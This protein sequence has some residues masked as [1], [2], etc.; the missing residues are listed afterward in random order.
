VVIPR[1]FEF[2]H[3]RMTMSVITESDEQ[4]RMV[5]CKGAAEKIAELCIPESLPDGFIEEAEQW[6]K[7]GA[8]VLG[9]CCKG[10]DGAVDIH[11]Y[12]RDDVEEKQSFKCL[13]L[14]LFR[15][16]LKEDTKEAMT[17][18][19]EG[20]CRTI[21]ITGDNA[22]CGYYIAKE[23]GMIAK[24]AK[25]Y[26]ADVSRQDASMVVWKRQDAGKR[27]PEESVGKTDELDS[28]PSEAIT[29]T[30]TELAMTGK[31]FDILEKNGELDNLILKTRI[32]ARAS[33]N[34]KTL[35]IRKLIEKGIVCGYCGD[36]GNDCGALRAAHAGLALSEAEAS[37]VAPFTGK[38]KSVMDMVNL[39]REG[40]CAL[41]TSFA[42]WKFI[43]SFGQSYIICKLSYVY[44]DAILPSIDYIFI[45]LIA[46]ISIS[47]ALT[48]SRPLDK[49]GPDRPTASLL[50]PVTVMGVLGQFFINLVFACICWAVIVVDDDYN[51][52]PIKCE[53]GNS[54]WLMGDNWEAF[55]CMNIFIFQI[56]TA[57][58]VFGFGSRFRKPIWENYGLLFVTFMGWL[59]FTLLL[60]LPESGFTKAFHYPQTNF[61]RYRSDSTT[62]NMYQNVNEFG[63]PVFGADTDCA[64]WAVAP[65]HVWNSDVDTTVYPTMSYC[66][67]VRPNVTMTDSYKIETHKKSEDGTWTVVPGCFGEV[68]DEDED[69]VVNNYTLAGTEL[70]DKFTMTYANV[71]GDG[72]DDEDVII[73]QNVWDG[74]NIMGFTGEVVIANV[75][76][77][78]Q[79]T[80]DAEIMYFNLD[81]SISDDGEFKPGKEHNYDKCVHAQC[82]AN[83]IGCKC[84][85]TDDVVYEPQDSDYDMSFSLRFKLFIIVFVNN[86]CD[87]LFVWQVVDGVGRD[88]FRTVKPDYIFLDL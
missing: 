17:Q 15:N 19:K 18:L 83:K 44:F 65:D 16:E 68:M 1:R 26:L 85:A 20:D 58:F 74:F 24:D 28:L 35:V 40:R 39:L 87:I 84:G 77:Y 76:R 82:W 37:V 81:Y 79:H 53:D 60:L 38:D 51:K 62:W 33:P 75:G 3:A 22:Q 34:Q 6:A 69:V 86:L 71:M 73:N 8:Y 12:S 45:D 66:T 30:G 21:M 59:V 14:I 56:F 67:L 13:G 41:A 64:Y 54:W 48:L 88:Y 11:D 31:A 23:S 2:D 52:W 47:F 78:T 25:V 36:G 7:D 5:Y 61:N 27:T 4:G 70:Q 55:N 42:V 80:V 49:L 46:E 9:L 57:G 32:Y 72:F 43:L 63:V 10:M 29:D 50:G